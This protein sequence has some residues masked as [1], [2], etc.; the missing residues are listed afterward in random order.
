MD[1]LRFLQSEVYRLERTPKQKFKSFLSALGMAGLALVY[2]YML[3]T[4][5]VEVVAEKAY[6]E[7]Y[8]AARDKLNHKELALSDQEFYNKL[9]NAWWFKADGTERRLKK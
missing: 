3:G 4:D 2:G 1:Y 9:C 8:A 7:G 5:Q 6:D